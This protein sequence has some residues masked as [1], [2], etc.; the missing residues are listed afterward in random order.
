MEAQ[1]SELEVRAESQVD[2]YVGKKLITTTRPITRAEM[3]QIR[4]QGAKLRTVAVALLL[5][6]VP[7]VILLIEAL[8]AWRAVPAV[9]LN[10]LVL[11]LLAYPADLLRLSFLASKTREG[12]LVHVIEDNM[13]DNVDPGLP[14]AV[15]STGLQLRPDHAVLSSL[16]FRSVSHIN[17]IPSADRSRIEEELAQGRPVQPRELTSGERAEA[18]RTPP[19]LALFLI[20]AAGG[21]LLVDASLKS[22]VL[23][24]ASAATL[25]V[26]F[27]TVVA[28]K[29]RLARQPLRIETNVAYRGRKYR[30]AEFLGSSSRPW[31]L[32]GEPADWR[33]NPWTE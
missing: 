30:W 25:G 32:E 14:V 18:S 17:R 3:E 16:K 6:L 15:S 22:A 26:V 33:L 20:M 8:L 29:A 12:A 21:P 2:V 4:R 19:L 7:A 23:L 1:V 10:I 31:S 13:G 5:L 28:W 24:L 27:V 9:I 11:G